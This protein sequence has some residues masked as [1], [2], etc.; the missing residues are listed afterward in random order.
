MLYTVGF[1]SLRLRVCRRCRRFFYFYSPDTA[2]AHSRPL[3]HFHELNFFT[4]NFNFARASNFLRRRRAEQFFFYS[5]C[6]FPLHFAGFLHVSTRFFFCALDF[7]YT[8]TIIIIY[9]ALRNIFC[10]RASQ[11]ELPL[12]NSVHYFFACNGGGG[13]GGGSGGSKKWQPSVSCRS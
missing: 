11:P 12:Y 8:N 3:S 10:T 2:I 5:A 13:G 7:Y 4:L 9:F 6:F 1:F